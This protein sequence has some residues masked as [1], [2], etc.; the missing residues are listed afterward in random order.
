[1][2]PTFSMC[3]GAKNDEGSASIDIETRG[4]MVKRFFVIIV[5]AGYFG[6]FIL[7]TTGLG[8]HWHSTKRA[9]HQP[10][11]FPH[12]VHVGKLKIACHFCHFYADK[13]RHAGVP[14][15]ETCM[16]C[17]SAI[18]TDKPEIQKLARYYEEKRPIEWNQVY[19]VPDHVYFSHKRHVKAKVNCSSCHGDVGTM[20]KIRKVRSLDMGWC[21]SCHKEKGAPLDCATCHK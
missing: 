17:H 6:A 10:M 4:R 20:E 13:S 3:W 16:V 19:V 12:T 5:I 2:P 21:V 1:M 14:Y 18:A 8:Y 7:L 11:A 15:V 9:P